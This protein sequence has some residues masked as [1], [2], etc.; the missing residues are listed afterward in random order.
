MNGKE[1]CE[2]LLDALL[3]L[4]EEMLRE[5]GEFYPY[6]GY[7]TLSGEIVH[8]GAKDEDT[9][10]PKSKDLLHVLRDSF[11]EMARA[12]GCKATAVVF[13]VH[14]NSPET[15]AKNDAIQVSLEHVE[16]YCVEVFFPYEIAGNVLNYGAT[17]ANETEHEI[18]G[19][20]F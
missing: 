10:H 13:D 9:N 11:S 20:I 19:K 5:Y 6:G 8:V 7:M 15:A 16:G 14:V 1:D 2:K 12:G 4:A 18:F 17:Y 3:P